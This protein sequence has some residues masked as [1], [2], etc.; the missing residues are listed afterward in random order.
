MA[1]SRECK[2]LQWTEVRLGEARR[3]AN[4]HQEEERGEQRAVANCE[5]NQQ[6]APT[7]IQTHTSRYGSTNR[8]T[9]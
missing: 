8:R 3:E 2:G 7:M 1:L 4:Q 5:Q 9:H 6:G